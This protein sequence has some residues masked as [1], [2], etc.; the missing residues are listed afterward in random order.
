MESCLD[1]LGLLVNGE[2]SRQDNPSSISRVWS[3]LLHQARASVDNLSLKKGCI[4]I[5]FDREFSGTRKHVT[6]Q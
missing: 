1:Y 6:V 2:R 5:A 3:G 4:L